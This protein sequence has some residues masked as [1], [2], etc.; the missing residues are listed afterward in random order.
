MMVQ[1]KNVQCRDLKFK[2]FQNPKVLESCR[3]NILENSTPLNCFI[4]NLLKILYKMTSGFEYKVNMKQK[5]Y[6]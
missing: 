2:M 1:D 5:F 6:V 4:Q 3:Y